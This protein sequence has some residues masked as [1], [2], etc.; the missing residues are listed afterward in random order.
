M[1]SAGCV[2]RK[3]ET[4]VFTSTYCKRTFT[5]LTVDKC[6]VPSVPASTAHYLSLQKAV[7]GKKIDIAVV[8]YGA[9]MCVACKK[10]CVCGV[11]NR[12]HKVSFVYKR[13]TV[14]PNFTV[15]FAPLFKSPI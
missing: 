2:S 9:V 15:T 1:I 11:D 14:A 3:A 12:F 13:F 6:Q 8:A 4:A 7:R 5:G 10:I